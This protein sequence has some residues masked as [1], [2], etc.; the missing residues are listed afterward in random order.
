MRKEDPKQLRKVKQAWKKPPCTAA[1]PRLYDFKDLRQR[2]P[3]LDEKGKSRFAKLNQTTSFSILS[4]AST[5]VAQ[6]PRSK[7]L[8]H[9]EPPSH[10]IHRSLSSGTLSLKRTRTLQKPK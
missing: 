1:A 3:T 9:T 2:F 5:L 8:R 7:S 10:R 6:M 4:S